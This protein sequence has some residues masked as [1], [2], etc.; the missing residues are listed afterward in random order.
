M[1]ETQV[2]SLIWEDPTCQGTTKPICHNYWACAPDSGS[3]N[4]WAHV[5]KLLKFKCPRACALQQEKPHNEKPMHGNWRVALAH[6]SLRKPT[7]QWWP[8]AAKNK[9]WINTVILKSK[10]ILCKLKFIKQHFPIGGLNNKKYIFQEIFP[11]LSVRKHRFK[12][13]NQIALLKHLLMCFVG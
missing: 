3:H 10:L 9:Y 4:Y 7:Q 13:V 12:K 5:L 6:N 8:S 11:C 2:Q 1:K